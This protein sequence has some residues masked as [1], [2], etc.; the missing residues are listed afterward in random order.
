MCLKVILK[1]FVNN[2]YNILLNL[3]IENGENL[4]IIELEIL[5]KYKLENS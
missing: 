5:K 3:E 2:D 1:I 4:Q